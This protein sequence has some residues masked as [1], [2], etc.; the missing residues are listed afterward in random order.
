[1]ADTKEK[2]YPEGYWR[3]TGRPARLFFMSAYLAVPLLLFLLHIRLWTFM[4]LVLTIA[5]LTFIEQYGYTPAIALLALRARIA[6]KRV[7]RRKSMF[8]KWLDN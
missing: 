3:D 5:V 1:M 8:N 2:K 4:L 6:G 7:K